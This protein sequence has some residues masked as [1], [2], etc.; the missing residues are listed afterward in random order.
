MDQEHSNDSVLAS[1][2]DFAPEDETPS[3]LHVPLG[4]LGSALVVVAYPVLWFLV[5]YAAE[6]FTISAPNISIWFPPA[7]LA[8][9]LL[10]V[11]GLRFLPLLALGPAMSYFLFNSEG[12]PVSAF[13][14][15]GISIVTV[16]GSVAALLLRKVEIDPRLPRLSDVLWFVALTA[17]GALV[18]GASQA[19]NVAAHG[20]L[21]WGE[22]P[23]RT[24][25][26]W[27]GDVSGI[28][29]L[30]PPLL[31]GA[32]A[33]GALWTREP[34]GAD[35][36]EMPDRRPVLETAREWAG[37]LGLL[38][39]TLG[40][41]LVVFGLPQR[42]TL[43]H[44]YVLFLPVI[45]AA[46]RHGFAYASATVLVLN[47][48]VVLV[49]FIA[50]DGEIMDFDINGPALQFALVTTTLMGVLLGAFM[51][52]RRRRFVQLGEAKRKAEAADRLKASLLMNM[53][54]EVRTPLTAILGYADVLREE[55][56]EELRPFAAEVRRGGDRLLD[57]L[58][59][60]LEQAQ[61]ESGL[62]ELEPQR[63][64]VIEV[65]RGVTESFEQRAAE[66]GLRLG[67]AARAEG[68][69]LPNGW[70]DLDPKGL[71]TVLSH[72]LTNALK[73]TREGEVRVTCETNPTS[74]VV[75]VEDTG[76]GIP[77]DTLAH[78]FEPFHQ[79]SRGMNRDFE[80]T[81]LGLSIAKH[82]VDRMGGAI[83]AQSE[84]GAGSC[85]AVRFEKTVPAAQP[86]RGPSRAAA[87]SRS[88]G[89]A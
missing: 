86:H 79:A 8:Y 36:F 42:P 87:A 85:F 40:A 70:V 39:F 12:L 56:D 13:V 38:V 3:A 15:Y 73:F 67:F 4:G 51:S 78:V 72:L 77:A 48:A 74:V 1:R 60:I 76:V 55:A 34:A 66:R 49:F 43:D 11:F 46:V 80:G 16:F 84:P 6:Y 10:L 21:P 37:A 65:A 52:D 58:T 33:I 5:R 14:V 18:M 62:V 54:H 7:A 61:I 35:V 82:Y 31:L 22:V 75:R 30:A 69:G 47:V 44:T 32:G 88:R 19:V 2:E 25:M 45:W 26:Y 59:L 41:A 64:D 27:A 9:V 81:G 57:T 24:L 71:H 83:T 53:S 89:T 28:V 20:A 63:V 23:I 50:A 17:A 29:A 68:S